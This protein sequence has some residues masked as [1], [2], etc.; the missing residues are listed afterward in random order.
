MSQASPSKYVISTE[1]I[2]IWQALGNTVGLMG[3]LRP[4]GGQ[5]S[6]ISATRTIKSTY[7]QITIYSLYCLCVHAGH[8]Q[9]NLD[10]WPQSSLNHITFQLATHCAYSTPGPCFH[11]SSLL[12]CIWLRRRN[13]GV[14]EE[15]SPFQ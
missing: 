5:V 6:I 4:Q 7:P 2:R 13:L 15:T 12:L 1:L 10:P 9:R 11:T 3:C 8:T 14:D